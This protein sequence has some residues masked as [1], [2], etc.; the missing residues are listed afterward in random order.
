[1]EWIWEEMEISGEEELYKEALRS[2]KL[3]FHNTKLL[4]GKEEVNV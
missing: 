2:Y 4:I 1:M 3:A